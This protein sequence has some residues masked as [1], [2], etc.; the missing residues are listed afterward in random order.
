MSTRFSRLLISSALLASAAGAHDPPQLLPWVGSRGTFVHEPAGARLGGTT[1]LAK[2]GDEYQFSY[3]DPS[4]EDVMYVVDVGHADVL[5][6]LL[7]IEERD[8]TGGAL[9]VTE[10]GLTW[11]NGSG[12]VQSPRTHATAA[13]TVLVHEAMDANG[14][15]LW[16][17]Y[18]EARD[19]V[20]GLKTY[21]FRLVGKA[22]KVRAWADETVNDGGL[23]NYVG[24]R[25]GPTD[26][27]PNPRQQHVPYMDSVPLILFD[28]SA[29][30][31][32]ETYFYAAFLDFYRS[33]GSNVTP[34][35]PTFS[36]DSAEF[37]FGTEYY[38]N[39][40]GDRL[41]R[42]DETVN[43]L[44]TTSIEQTFPLIAQDKSPYRDLT[45]GRIGFNMADNASY[46]WPAAQAHFDALSSWGVDDVLGMFFAWNKWGLNM[47][48]PDA[49]AAG[50]MGCDPADLVDDDG[51][52][53]S[54]IGGTGPTYTIDGVDPDNSTNKTAGNVAFGAAMDAAA[55]AGWLMA[56]YQDSGHLD[57]HGYG[58]YAGMQGDYPGTPPL[59]WIGWPDDTSGHLRGLLAPAT[60]P[61]YSADAY[62]IVTDENGDP[63]YGWDTTWNL[64]NATTWHGEGHA[65]HV[66]SPTD[67][68]DHFTEELA[69]AVGLFAPTALFVDATTGV[70]SWNKIDRLVG[71]GK[72]SRIWQATFDTIGALLTHK[73]DIGGPL[74]GENN[75]FRYNQW[76]SFE[77]GLWDGRHRKFP[78]DVGNELT[79]DA[80]R[81]NGD[82]WVIPDY[83]LT[84]VGPLASANLGM[85]WEGQHLS[86][87]YPV[88]GSS[89]AT[90]AF[91]DSW[92]T[93]IV[94]FGHSAYFGTNGHVPNNYWTCEGILRSYY[95]LAG[96]QAAQR[97]GGVPVVEYFINNS[98]YVEL[99]TAVRE[100]TAATLLKNPRIRLTY[101]SGLVIWA[102]HDVAGNNGWKVSITDSPPGGSP[103][104]FSIGLPPNGFVATDPSGLLVFSADNPQGSGPSAHRIDYAR[105]PGRWE[106]MCTRG[107]T[108]QK[109]NGFPQSSLINQFSSPTAAANHTI[110]RND[111]HN[112]LVGAVGGLYNYQ[113]SS[114]ASGGVEAYSQGSA[115]SPTTLVLAAQDG[116]TELAAGR[117][118]GITATLH[119]G[120]DANG[121]E[122]TRDVTPLAG[123]NLSAGGSYA[124]IDERGALTGVM[125]GGT[126]TISASYPGATL[127]STLDI[128]IVEGAP[129]AAA[130]SNQSVAAG[131]FLVLDGSASS[132][133]ESAVISGWWDLGSAD[134]PDVAGLRAKVTY[135]VPGTYN[136]TLHV[137]DREAHDI[138]D[139]AVITVTGASD[140][141][142]ADAFGA[143]LL[144][145]HYAWNPA[146]SAWGMQ[147]QQLVQKLTSSSEQVI[148]LRGRQVPFLHVAA[149]I[150]LDASAGST[151]SAGIH[152]RKTN[153]ADGPSASGYFAALQ[154]NGDLV[155]SEA[156]TSGTPV[157]I[158]SFNASVPHLME[159]EVVQISSGVVRYRCW[160]D[161]TLRVSRQDGSPAPGEYLGLATKQNLATFDDL[162]VSER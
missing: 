105:I 1:S 160:I 78:V 77:A 113:S 46:A 116:A 32:T 10:G 93:N 75:H 22:L 9:I 148:A 86:T 57:Q 69:D 127:A 138:A 45:A 28:D 152:V 121:S 49:D 6:G 92:W 126:A 36:G 42:V 73:S 98:T 30:S 128:D 2:V 133:V 67:L 37:F 39:T 151:T 139:V 84:Q 17:R 38:P 132:D 115:P 120:Q 143:G 54:Q 71:S 125:D 109:Y 100:S 11:M 99:D 60:N 18:H 114:W 79:A 8:L 136:A 63:T 118:L 96:L 13:T 97:A 147:E 55:N 123:L 52:Y 51:N 137:A 108:T 124:S 155:I 24:F 135:H 26:L 145:D 35:G 87:G 72:A 70:P 94:T 59:S 119:L 34:W 41:A 83:E 157:S 106:M 25:I 21:E 7:R 131:G 5:D 88:D 107:D 3:A 15:T 129:T 50:C 162:A 66:I 19:G 20:Q 150:Q 58:P 31:P 159:V 153:E 12:T 33:N 56:L 85:G 68:Y 48:G 62:R 4:D 112:L 134:E 161:G 43:L 16:L 122:I 146:S 82:S 156:G 149:T 111:V 95:L 80:G 102:N 47:L 27:T 23:N 158:P 53:S 81:I 40:D 65:M 110:I 89:G 29:S 64:V 140:L 61:E 14:C 44:V 90:H 130:G 141:L 104:S 154:V 117:R 76:D 74:N 103:S 101:P 91:V 144:E 142:F